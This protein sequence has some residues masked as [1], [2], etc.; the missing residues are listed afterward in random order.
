[1]QLI[2]HRGAHQVGGSCIEL[3]HMGSTILLDIG[4]PLDSGF[5]DDPEDALPKPLFDEIRQGV[6]KIDGV[7]ISHAHMDHYG[8]ARMLPTDIPIYCGQASAE[9]IGITSKI[10]SH[11]SEEVAFQYYKGKDPFNIGHFTITPYLMDHSAFDSYALLVSAGG[12]SV[13]YTGDFRA[14]G[15]KAIIHQDLINNPPPVD[16]LI[17]EGTMVGSRS[18]EIAITEEELEDTFVRV[19]SETLGIV[20]VSTSSQNIDRLVTIFKAA[21]RTQRCFIVDFYTAEVLEILGKYAR[22]PQASWPR[23]R[24]CYPQLL[25]R[26][27]EESDNLKDIL[28]KH[29]KNGISWKKLKEIEHKAVMLIRPGFLWDIKRFLNLKNASWIYSMWPGYFETSKPLNKLRSYF[30]EKDVRI[31]YL[32]T[33]GH[34]KV[35]DLVRLTE[36]LKPSTTIPIHSAHAEKYKDYFSNVTLL[37]DGKI[38][39]I[40]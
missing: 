26:R 18:D 12:K 4:L 8:L 19:I 7:V 5:D 6:K 21:Q 40:E 9:L 27:F 11:N 16:V 28:A 36:A 25:A 3:T 17:M 37:N 10:R 39:R 29:R 30:Q 22:I 23:I 31:E 14:H 35:Q 15:R 1:M 13:F 32:H 2:I 24:V 33:G 34:A 38:F 20:M